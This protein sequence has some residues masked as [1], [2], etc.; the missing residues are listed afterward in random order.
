VRSE[1][2]ITRRDF[3]KAAGT[4]AAGVSAF[5]LA[6][7]QAQTPGTKRRY[8]IVGTGVRAVG[9]WGQQVAQQLGDSVEFVGLCDVNP[10]RLEAARRAMGVNCPTFTSLD[11]ML[12]QAKPDLL[13][14]T[15][16]AASR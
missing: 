8:A 4:A 2:S 10:L 15:S 14:V 7:L 5:G 6:S 11:A 9:M 1:S 3:V 12:D 16:G 13:M